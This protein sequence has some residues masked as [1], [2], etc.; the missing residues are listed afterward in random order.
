MARRTLKTLSLASADA[1]ETFKAL[2]SDVRIQ[3]LRELVDTDLNIAELGARLGMSQ[4]TVTRHVQALEAA[5]LV[6]SE[7]LPGQQ[8]LQKRCR[9]AVSHLHLMLEGDEQTSRPVETVSMPIGL[10]TLAVPGGTCGLASR[11]KFIGFLDKPLSF[12]DPERASAQI[13]WMGSGFVEYTFPND[14][15]TGCTVE[16]LEVQMEACSEAP[17]YNLD[18]P[19]DI[20]VWVNGVEVA[21]WTCP[22]D[23]GGVRGLLNP[24]WWPEHMTQ[25]GA[26]KVFSTDANGS[27]VDGSPASAV[28]ID[29]LMVVPQQPIVVRIGVKPD[30]AHQ[31]GFNLFG[32]G[33]GNYPQ[34]LVLRLHFRKLDGSRRQAALEGR[35]ES[36]E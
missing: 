31:G 18:W 24:D 8:G 34:D 1:L 32:S 36:A 4:P 20:T 28:T 2:A 10:Y 17:D 3:I 35:A 19:S 21:T 22:S 5:G 26:L 16:R 9:L 23:F 6:S 30:A 27:A 25:H 11:T 13:L 7:Y 29:Q 33:F 14:L 12:F 15:P